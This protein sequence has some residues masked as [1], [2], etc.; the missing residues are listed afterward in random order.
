MLSGK[1]IKANFAELLQTYT[2]LPL[3]P[4]GIFLCY[5]THQVIPQKVKE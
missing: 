2:A 4:S 1:G 5:H 3:K